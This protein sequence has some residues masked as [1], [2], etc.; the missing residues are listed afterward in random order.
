MTRMPTPGDGVDPELIAAMAS[1][2]GDWAQSLNQQIAAAGSA[3]RA[4]DAANLTVLSVAL[5]AL[6]MSSITLAL[7][8]PTTPKRVQTGGIVLL[9]G[10]LVTAGASFVV[11]I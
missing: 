10:A 4:G 3:E 7:A 2:P 5:A 9:V 11:Y 8:A 1:S 6:A